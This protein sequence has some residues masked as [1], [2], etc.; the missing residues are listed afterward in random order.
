MVEQLGTPG[1]RHVLSAGSF[2]ITLFWTGF[3][4]FALRTAPAWQQLRWLR[5]S[6]LRGWQ[7]SWHDDTGSCKWSR[8]YWKREVEIIC[9]RAYTARSLQAL[10]KLLTTPRA[11]TEPS[12]SAHPAL[13]EVGRA[14]S[15]VLGSF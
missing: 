12:L 10:C 1:C 8:A 7:G 3:F 14:C 11:I 5:G 13:N 2:E 9:H 4:F 15:D 6:W